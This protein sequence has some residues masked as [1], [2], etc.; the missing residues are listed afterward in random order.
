MVINDLKIGD[1]VC[2]LPLSDKIEPVSYGI[3]FKLEDY[4]S[5]SGDC[6]RKI[7]IK[8]NR[9]DEID[10]TIKNPIDHIDAF[11]CGSYLVSTSKSELLSYLSKLIQGIAGE[12][13]CPQ[14]VESVEVKQVH[15]S[16][17]SIDGINFPKYDAEVKLR[18]MGASWFVSYAYHNL[19]DRSHR[20]W[21]KAMNKQ[22]RLS[23]YNNGQQY[24]KTWVNMVLN[25]N[26]NKLR[27]NKIDLNAED[28]KRM[29]KKLLIELEKNDRIE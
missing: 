25:M 14:K 19:C 3:V 28:V 8:I 21:D 24:M 20:N 6:F 2:C 7:S 11:L 18:T 27:T 15:P 22:S 26:D 29:A 12:Y 10:C 13:D 17:K 4:L 5:E 1:S 23:S 9:V 16:V